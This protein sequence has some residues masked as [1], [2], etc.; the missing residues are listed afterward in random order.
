MLAAV[1]TLLSMAL[2]RGEY[3]AD[4]TTMESLGATPAQRRHY[5]AM[6][7]LV[8]LL[9]GLPTGMLVGFTIALPLVGTGLFGVF[10]TTSVHRLLLATG[11]AVLVLAV[12]ASA[13]VL[14][15]PSGDLIPRTQD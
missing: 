11:L 6:Q 7:A 2:G 12:G 13:A 3:A 5:G 10:L 8:L 1:A 14:A 4:L 9:A 15:R